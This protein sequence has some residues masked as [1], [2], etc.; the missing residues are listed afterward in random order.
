MKVLACGEGAGD[1]SLAGA[2][3]GDEGWEPGLGLG[4]GLMLTA[5]LQRSLSTAAD[6]DSRLPQ[7]GLLSQSCLMHSQWRRASHPFWKLSFES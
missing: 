5:G 6:D 2:G 3:A 7:R 1:G 4:L